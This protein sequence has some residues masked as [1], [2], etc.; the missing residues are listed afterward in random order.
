[1]MQIR[2]E[3]ADIGWCGCCVEM[4]LTL[5]A[6]TSLNIVL[7]LGPEKR[8][9]RITLNSGMASNPPACPQTPSMKLQGFFESALP[10]AIRKAERAAKA[11]DYTR[12]EDSRSW[13]SEMER[14]SV[15]EVS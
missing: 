9:S 4:A 1:M 6:G 3:M 12:D 2:A 14:T 7:W 10:N 13:R 5:S 11:H 15:N 8:S